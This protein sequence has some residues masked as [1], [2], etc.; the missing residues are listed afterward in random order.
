MKEV[1]RGEV[2]RGRVGVGGG[3]KMERECVKG[4]HQDEDKLKEGTDSFS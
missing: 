1:G 2:G 3:R 4:V